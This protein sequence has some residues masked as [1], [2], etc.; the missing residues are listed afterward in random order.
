[1][2][3]TGKTALRVSLGKY[4]Q[5]ASVSNLGYNTNPSLR[6]PGANA[7]GF[8]NPSVNRTWN[9]ADGDLNPDCVLT[10][11]AAN[12]ECGQISVLAFGSNN[13]V[14]SNFDPDLLHGWGLRPSD[15]SFG[16]SVQQQ[17]F[18]RASVEVGYYR[19]W[20]TMYSTGGTVNDNLAIGPNDVSSFTLTAPA[21]SRLPTGGGYTVGPLY[22]TNPDV[23]GQSNGFIESTKKVGDDTRLFNGVDVTFQVRNVKGANFS[24]GT[25]TGK[26]ENDFC[27]IRAAVPENY[28]LNPYCHPVS[29]WQTSLNGLVTYT[30]P[31]ID[32]LVSSVFRDRPNTSTDQLGSIAA[33]YTLRA[34]DITAAAAELGRS[35]TGSTFS[36]NL[37]GPGSVYGPRNRQVDVS[38]KKVVRLGAQ[39]MTAGLDI[40]NLA[41]SNTTLGFSQTFV[42]TATSWQTPTSYLNPRVFRLA[43]EYSW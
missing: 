33:N 16:A 23:F 20:F 27:D 4:L 12:G 26:V 35:M 8:S 6:I 17:L 13:F 3:G 30:V 15:W 10:D 29:P 7:S 1:V 25:S 40:Y 38:V 39:R 37:A 31:K 36:V 28:L 22:N 43:A 19:R 34:A 41:N 14:G 24:G 18:P 21:D 32:V 11:S 5:G 9:D 42:P 2:F